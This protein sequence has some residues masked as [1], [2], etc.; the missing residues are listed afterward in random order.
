MT[1]ERLSV[2]VVDMSRAPKGSVDVPAPLLQAPV[3]RHLLHEAVKAQQAAHRQGDAS[4]KTR[5]E[6]RGGGAKPW[7]QKGT[8]RAR[9]GSNRSPIWEGGGTTF[10]PRPR[11]YAYRLPK[12]ARRAALCSALSA[13]FGEER[14]IVVD[15]FSLAA[16]KTKEMLA[17]LSGLGVE[18]STLVVIDTPATDVL[19]A[20]RNLPSVKVIEACGLNVYDVLR[21]KSLVVT[22]AALDALAKRVLGGT[23][24]GA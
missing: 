7:R 2:P 4:T 14:V 1:A 17:A 10:G 23:D 6:V 9:A 15:A 12:S 24:E 16:P 8:G 11:S 5:G 20:A 18:G 22:T 21:H 13:R 3:N 19:R